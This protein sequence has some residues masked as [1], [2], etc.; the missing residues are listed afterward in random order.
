MT[1]N[2]GLNFIQSSDGEADRHAHAEPHLWGTS[3]ANLPENPDVIV[4]SDVVYDPEGY[5]PLVTSLDAL[6]RP[7][8]TILMAHRSR[9]P[10][11]HQFFTLLGEKFHYELIDWASDLKADVDKTPS[12]NELVLQDVKIFR[13]LRK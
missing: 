1:Y 7:E 8:T 12:T 2:I 3:I 6:A 5:V 10:M 9:N 4:L 11:E 13:L